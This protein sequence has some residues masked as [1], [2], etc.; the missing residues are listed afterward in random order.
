MNEGAAGRPQAVEAELHRLCRPRLFTACWSRL[1][2][3]RGFSKQ[4]Q[5]RDFLPAPLLVPFYI[6]DS[7]LQFD[8]VNGY[9]GGV[10]QTYLADSDRTGLQQ[11]QGFF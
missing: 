2:W 4:G 1:L 7:I 11:R 9:A 5:K 10:L 6:N 3:G 8:T